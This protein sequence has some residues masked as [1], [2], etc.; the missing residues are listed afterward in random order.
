MRAT[1]PSAK[2]IKY[3]SQAQDPTDFTTEVPSVAGNNEK[4]GSSSDSSF[5]AGPPTTRGDAVADGGLLRAWV[6][7]TTDETRTGRTIG[8]VDGR[9]W[10]SEDGT[11]PEPGTTT[12]GSV[13]EAGMPAF[14][15]MLAEGKAED[16]TRR[17]AVGK[18]RSPIVG[19]CSKA[20]L[21]VWLFFS[22]T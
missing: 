12:A 4:P 6:S 16:P 15:G 19:T 7:E 2:A 1:A 5:P 21:R 14:G 9:A 11:A 17:A 8:S 18:A 3:N 22:S 10:S 20:E 13:R